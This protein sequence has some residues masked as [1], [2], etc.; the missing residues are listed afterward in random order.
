MMADIYSN[1]LVSI[2]ASASNDGPGGCFVPRLDHDSYV[3][4]VDEM[5][6]SLLTGRVLVEPNLRGCF[7]REVCQGPLWSRGWVVQERL[8]S[9]RKLY[10]A[11]SQLY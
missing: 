1:A 7:R 3:R 6:T 5:P 9:P 10:Y 11:N 2:T 4:L 8:L